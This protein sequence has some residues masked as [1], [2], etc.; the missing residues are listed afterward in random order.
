M[1]YKIYEKLTDF[2]RLRLFSK[3]NIAIVA[4]MSIV[5][6]IALAGAAYNSHKDLETFLSLYAPEKS[7]EISTTLLA[8]EAYD[9][10]TTEVP[11]T[12]EVTTQEKSEAE[13]TEASTQ[14]EE[15]TSPVAESEEAQQGTYYVTSSG[16]KYHK[17]TCGYL[18]KSRIAISLND[19][20]AKGYSPCSR[21]IK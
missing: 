21:C 15:G 2:F 7:E 3:T 14:K 1:K 10:N 18:S 12:S 4:V 5:M 6:N 16:T 19:A 13:T 17:S 8:E 20:K 11:Q 9:E